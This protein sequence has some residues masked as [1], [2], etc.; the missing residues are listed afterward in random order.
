MTPQ[1]IIRRF[2]LEP[3]PEEGGF[4]RQVWRSPLRIGNAFL[5]KDYPPAQDHPLGTVIYFLI[6]ENDFS[7]LHRLP[8]PEH[9]F[10]H[11]GD[12]LEMLLLHP[13]GRGEVK[14]LGANF[15]AQEHFHI[16]TPAHSWQGTRISTTHLKLGWALVS[17]VMI[18]GWEESDFTLAQKDE[19][20]AQYP[21]WQEE[22][23]ARVR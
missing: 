11:A 1:E 20:L 10:F 12:P 6:T 18:P 7:A 21:A 19:L 22:I 2:Q 14:Y 15:G 16:T 3:L 5:G 4:F 13:D 9:W 23:L 17:A 8:T